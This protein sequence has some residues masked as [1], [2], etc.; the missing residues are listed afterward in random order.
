MEA[1]H[2]RL[3]EFLRDT[4][5]SQDHKMTEIGKDHGGLSCPTPLLN[6]GHLE[7]QD[8]DQMAF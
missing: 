8:H 7:A 6:Q 1:K 3:K 4:T 5:E 2:Y